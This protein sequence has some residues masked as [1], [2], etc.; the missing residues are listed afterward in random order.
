MTTNTHTTSYA[1]LE[2]HLGGWEAQG[3]YMLADAETGN[4]Y[5]G[6]DQVPSIRG[7]VGRS[8]EAGQDNFLNDVRDNER[9]AGLLLQYVRDRN[10]AEFEALKPLA[11]A[12]G[13]DLDEAAENYAAP[14]PRVP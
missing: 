10:P 9:E 12:K 4:I 7:T 8:K 5:W 2:N 14:Q 11:A 3:G 1:D 13:F 6:E